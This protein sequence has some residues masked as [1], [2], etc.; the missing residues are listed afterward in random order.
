MFRTASRAPVFLRKLSKSYILPQSIQ[1]TAVTRRGWTHQ[2][3][4]SAPATPLLGRTSARAARP[5]SHHLHQGACGMSM[6]TASDDLAVVYVT[7]EEENAQNLAHGLVDAEL[8]AC[9]NIVPGMHKR[10][11]HQEEIF[12]TGI[13][14]L[15]LYSHCLTGITSVYRWKVDVCCKEEVLLIIKTRK[16]R[17]SSSIFNLYLTGRVWQLAR[18]PTL[19]MY[20]CTRNTFRRSRPG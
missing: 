11:A 15:T 12:G 1:A 2:L 20:C 17:L 19:K 8:A 4:G 13:L 16:A 10:L 18:C 14:V 5:N 3:V 7:A 6:Y 9:V